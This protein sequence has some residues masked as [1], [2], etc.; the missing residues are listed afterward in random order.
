MP[1]KLLLL[2]TLLYCT[3]VP[4]QMQVPSRSSL[5]NYDL[6]IRKRTVVDQTETRFEAPN[7]SPDG[8]YLL[9]NGDGKLFVMLDSARLNIRCLRHPM[10]GVTT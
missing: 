5:K 2:F 1:T 7:W 3:R 6:D 4:A 9:L 10:F 8:K